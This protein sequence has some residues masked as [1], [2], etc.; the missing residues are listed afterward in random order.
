[1]KL[2]GLDVLN[3]F[4][5]FDPSVWG[6][7]LASEATTAVTAWAARERPELPVI[8]RVRPA[9]V[10]SRDVARKAS[11][12]RAP[13]LDSHGQDGLDWIFAANLPTPNR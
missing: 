7:G 11:L 9:N 10:A 12:T 6:Q 8:A 4:Y 2:G 3:L 1:M 13:H 5:R